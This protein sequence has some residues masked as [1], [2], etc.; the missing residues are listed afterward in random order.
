MHVEQ[1]LVFNNVRH[2]HHVLVKLDNTGLYLTGGHWGW[3]VGYI[4]VELYVKE[5]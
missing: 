1:G 4:E 3:P 2:D 5:F